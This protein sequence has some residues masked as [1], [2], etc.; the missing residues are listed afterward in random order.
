MSPIRTQEHERKLYKYE[1]I[2]QKNEP[3]PRVKNVCEKL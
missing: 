2:A 3:A 1:V